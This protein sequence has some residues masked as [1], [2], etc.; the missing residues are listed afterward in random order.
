MHVIFL[1]CGF[2]SDFFFTDAVEEEE[3]IRH[4]QERIVK[5]RKLHAGQG[6]D[7]TDEWNAL[8]SDGTLIV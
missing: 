4:I 1:F 5:K 7:F 6:Q 3:A 8:V 2:F